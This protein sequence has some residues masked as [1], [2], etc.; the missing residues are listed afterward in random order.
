MATH[1]TDHV[2]LVFIG[3]VDAGK[4]TTAG[5]LLYLMGQVDQRT[6]ERCEEEARAQA[7][8]GYAKAYIMDTNQEE[9]TRGKTQE[10]ALAHFTT[11]TRRFTVLDAPG[12][13]N[14]VP[15]MIEGVAR[16][17]VAVLVVSA[18]AGEFE[19]GFE[20]DGQTREH[21]MLA[22]TLG[23]SR[24]IVAVNK[25]DDRTVNWS[26]DR[27]AEIVAK[28]RPFLGKTAG[29][30]APVF[31]PMSGASGANLRDPLEEETAPWY[32]GPSLVQALAT[33]RVPRR[34]PDGPLRMAVTM[35]IKEAGKVMLG[36]KVELGTIRVG[37]DVTV[38]GGHSTGTVQAIESDFAP[39]LNEA[40]AGDIVR[41]I[42]PCDA[43]SG[44][45]LSCADRPLVPVDRFEAHI[46][47]LELPDH[48]PVLS[49]GYTAVLHVHGATTECSIECI[50][51][52]LDRRTGQISTDQPKPKFARTGDSLGVR[53]KTAGNPVYLTTF[54]ELPR[55]GRFTLR[56]Q[57]KTVA[58]GKV[59][60]LPG[61]RP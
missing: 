27:Y 35:R 15:N 44:D 42:V 32:K 3:H 58:V 2:S 22:R 16:A 5:H 53:I 45:I 49:A 61:A 28:L 30:G 36:G 59:I 54:D 1:A 47:V 29:F 17:D 40:R 18:R 41:I 31:L 24:L 51:G 14:Y 7:G 25:M 6:V 19:A 46:S 55:L 9:R 12:H 38:G 23:V 20:R 37:Q 4:S 13:R 21:A 50:T 33:I 39:N 34:D 52:T 60:R 48:K 43:R 56:D 57:G 11:P 26:G 10:V 8:A